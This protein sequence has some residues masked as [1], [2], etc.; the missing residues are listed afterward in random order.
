MSEVV[1]EMRERLLMNRSGKLTSNQW[2]D[3]VTQPFIGLLV[4]F[5][6][7]SFILLPR[8]ITVFV[9]GGWL[10]FLVAFGILAGSALFRAIRYAR[11]PINV[12]EFT[13]TA[14]SASIWTMGRPVK[15]MDDGKQMVRFRRRL[16]PR[17]LLQQ[18]KRYLVYY[19]QDHKELV[20]LSLVGL[21]HP[22]I[23]LYQPDS[24]FQTRFRQRTAS[25]TR[26]VAE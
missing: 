24:F 6:P 13:A 16:A 5:V 7:L 25:T 8:M 20:L 14:Q 17:P 2:F 4:F 1:P 3:I 18:D 10:A 26:K 21:D 22:K 9:R 15:L 19:L 11:M 12:G 23:N